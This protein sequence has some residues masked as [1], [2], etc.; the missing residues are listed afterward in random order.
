[1]QAFFSRN[2]LLGWIT[3]AVVLVA[4]SLQS[5]GA[6][7][8]LKTV[9]WN[10]ESGDSS[11]SHIESVIADMEGVD[12]FAF[13]EV[14]PSWA[15]N[16]SGAAEVGEGAKGDSQAQFDYVVGT[17]GD[18]IRLVIVWDN[19]RFEKI[20]DTIELHA[21]NSGG[22]RHRSPLYIELRHRANNE[23]FL[24]MVNHLA[25]GD[26]FVR[27]EQARGLVQW[28]A[29]QELP[30]IA[31]GDY[32]FDFDIDEGIGNEAFDAMLEGSNW[33]WLKPETL[34]KSQSSPSYYSILDFV[35]VVNLSERWT[36][37]SSIVSLYTPFDDDQLIADHRPLEA[38]FFIA[39]QVEE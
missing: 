11:L 24:V 31:F 8:R 21:L 5:M 29:E 35:F 33:T 9:F 25:R 32:N 38:T 1:M 3:V 26:A 6:N 12:V 30:I 39:P 37:K 14:V 28:A 19:L 10:I 13:A 4:S 17:T 15:E 27:N 2:Y 23:R 18:D 20:G 16:L 22:L 34:M 36:S 7:W